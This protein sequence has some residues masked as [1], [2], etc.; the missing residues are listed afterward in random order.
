MRRFV[1]WFRS[2]REDRKTSEK[3]FQRWIA[4]AGVV[5][6]I[7]GVVVAV[8]GALYALQQLRDSHTEKPSV[9][10]PAASVSSSKPLT[11][12]STMPSDMPSVGCYKETKLVPC[13]ADHD[14]QVYA[15][16]SG[17]E[18]DTRSLI[19]YLGGQPGLDI[20]NSDIKVKRFDNN[21]SL[22]VISGVPLP[23]NSLENIWRA[24]YDHNGYSDG[25]FLRKCISFQSQPVSCDDEHTAEVFYE[26]AED[27]DCEKKYSEFVGRPLSGDQLLVHSP[28]S[29]CQVK[30]RSTSDRLFASVRGLED[31]ALPIK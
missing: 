19:I 28:K 23:G 6:A 21:S 4:I 5:I 10:Q 29:V 2:R 25:G 14:T 9:T 7:V 30:V 15:P 16:A 8:P 1:D 13:S 27:V 22:C 12:P 26:G 17:M 18:C 24:D 31:K 11:K 3:K 20:L